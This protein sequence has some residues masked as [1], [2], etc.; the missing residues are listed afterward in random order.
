LPGGPVP[1]NQVPS[2][3]YQQWLVSHAVASGSHGA[4]RWYE[5]RDP[6]G[7]ITPTVFQLGTYDPDAS[8]RF[9]SSL[10]ADKNGSIAMTG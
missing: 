5:F 3:T 2:S 10:A 7:S 6:S 8:W 4:V 1:N 9:M